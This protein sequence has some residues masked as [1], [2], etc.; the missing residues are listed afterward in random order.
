MMHCVR[1]YYTISYLLLVMVGFLLYL[2]VAVGRPL[3]GRMTAS[4]F[5]CFVA[6]RSRD[7]V[8]GGPDFLVRAEI[9]A[10]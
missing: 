6:G 5:V 7:L 8:R 2:S 10:P 4:M 3:G 1:C 9:A